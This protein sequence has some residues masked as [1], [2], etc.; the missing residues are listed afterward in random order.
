MFSY[1]RTILKYYCIISLPKFV[2]LGTRFYYCIKS[3]RLEIAE[4][5]KVFERNMDISEID[6]YERKCICEKKTSHQT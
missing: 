5:K 3:H 6:Q 2:V 1:F 4:E